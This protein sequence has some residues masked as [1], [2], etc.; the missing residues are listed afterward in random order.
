MFPRHHPSPIF[1]HRRYCI[2]TT[3][4][5]LS[6]SSLQHFM[7][8][9]LSINRRYCFIF[10]CFIL[11]V[12]I[13]FPIGN[14]CKAITCFISSIQS[15]THHELQSID[16]VMLWCLSGSGLMCVLLLIHLF[17]FPLFARLT[18]ERV[19][20]I[21]FWCQRKLRKTKEKCERLKERV[22]MDRIN[23]IRVLE[24]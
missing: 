4:M 8:Y 20:P 5:L 24:P 19:R 1:H 15:L 9:V 6:F 16:L 23:V 22:K 13:F 12:H 10:F 11:I 18:I 21:W 3:I 2:P 14:L 17:I 7:L